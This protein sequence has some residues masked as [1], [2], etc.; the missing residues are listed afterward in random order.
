MGTTIIANHLKSGAK[1]Y[2]GQCP[3]TSKIADGSLSITTTAVPIED[4]D[5]ASDVVTAGSILY[6]RSDSPSNQNLYKTSSDTG[7]ATQTLRLARGSSDVYTVGA[8]A[9]S[10]TDISTSLGADTV[11][12]YAHAT[13]AFTIGTSPGAGSVNFING[14]GPFTTAA[15]GVITTGQH[16]AGDTFTSSAGTEGTDFAGDATSA[17]PLHTA[18]AADASLTAGKILMLAGRRYKI[19]EGIND[20]TIGGDIG[21]KLTETFAGG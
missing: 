10:D 14:H 7:L 18:V 19:K 11:T 8:A 15:D 4:H 16:L 20:A 9:D 2:S 17:M 1:L 3:F 13:S 12:A 6:R 21:V 5:C